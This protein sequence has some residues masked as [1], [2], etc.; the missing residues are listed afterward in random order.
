MLDNNNAVDTAKSAAGESQDEFHHGENSLESSPSEAIAHLLAYRSQGVTGEIEATVVL[1]N[2][3]VRFK[4][5]S[6]KLETFL[7]GLQDAKV[8]SLAEATALTESKSASRVSK[9]I[10]IADYRDSLLDS[11]IVSW[12]TPG[13]SSHYEL[14]LLIEEVEKGQQD[15]DR[16]AEILSECDGEIT[17]SWLTDRRKRLR[18]NLG[19][20]EVS[21]EDAV[22][23]IDPT[24]APSIQLD[25][26]DGSSHE[27]ADSEDLESANRKVSALLITCTDDQLK[28]FE[29]S[30]AKN[31]NAP[32]VKICGNIDANAV[33]LVEATAE[34]LL[35]M[36]TT[37]GSLGFSRC[38][39]VGLLCKLDGQD[40]TSSRLL[41]IY[42]RGNIDVVPV[43]DWQDDV[44]AAQLS[45]QV[46]ENVRGR[47]VYL[48]APSETDG[49]ESLVGD[50]NWRS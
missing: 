48:F 19:L 16:V 46:L 37:I 3:L 9:L 4:G 12:L 6:A 27:N 34:T 28:Q 26:S 5:D 24:D 11:R 38:I 13:Y 50:A 23:E 8:L 18:G 41:A 29:D 14:S 7:S 15:L 40:I 43:S 49:W 30:L 31:S 10:K 21:E 35:S 2:G 22:A 45:E 39:Q 1:A 47:C 33:L 25:T 20:P 17:R 42:V 44:T 36:S 32:C